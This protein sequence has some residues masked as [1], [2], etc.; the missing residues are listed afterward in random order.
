MYIFFSNILSSAYI[1]ILAHIWVESFRSMILIFRSTPW[2]SAFRSVI[3]YVKS[4][5]VRKSLYCV[6]LNSIKTNLGIRHYSF[7]YILII[8]LIFL[9]IVLHHVESLLVNCHTCFMSLCRWFSD[10]FSSKHA[11]KLTRI[12]WFSVISQSILNRFSSNFAKAIFY[13]NPNS[14]E[15]FVKS[16]SAFQKLDHLTCNKLKLRRSSLTPLN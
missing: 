10:S 16:Y 3:Q 4:F 2:F 13:S 12:A 15:N 7:V 9:M 6:L 1:N 5:N 8:L 11:V 14:P